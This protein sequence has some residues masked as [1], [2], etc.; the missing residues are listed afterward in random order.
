MSFGKRVHQ[1][2]LIYN[3]CCLSNLFLIKGVKMREFLALFL[4]VCLILENFLNTKVIH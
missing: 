2:S 3:L 1:V 4:P